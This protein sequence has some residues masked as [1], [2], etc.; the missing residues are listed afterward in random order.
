MSIIKKSE[1]AQTEKLKGDKTIPEFK[2]GETV[3]DTV[4]IKEVD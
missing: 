2:A 3:K 4:K 1:Q